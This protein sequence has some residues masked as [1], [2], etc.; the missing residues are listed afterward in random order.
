[1]QR[2]CSSLM[3][4]RTFVAGQYS[5]AFTCVRRSANRISRH[6][7]RP[8][9]HMWMQWVLRCN[10]ADL[11]HSCYPACCCPE[12]AAAAHRA[13]RSLRCACCCRCPLS[14]STYKEVVGLIGVVGPVRAGFEQLWEQLVKALQTPRIVKA[15]F[16]FM[17]G[18]A[19]L[20]LLAP[21]WVQVACKLMQHSE[22]PHIE[23]V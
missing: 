8:W 2:T 17:V 16:T 3:T 19:P 12:P 4:S 6:F 21:G 23:G 15:A 10:P 14:G 7:P 5:H 13:H 11:L 20:M 18:A 22:Q 1:M 9:L